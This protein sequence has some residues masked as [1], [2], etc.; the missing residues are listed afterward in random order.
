MFTQAVH[1]KLSVRGQLSNG[2]VSLL[3]GAGL[4]GWVALQLTSSKG[5]L[6][7][8]LGGAG[9][10]LFLLVRLALKLWS[11]HTQ[12]IS[13]S[14]GRIHL[15]SAIAGWRAR[16][17]VRSEVDML[18][19]Q[20]TSS[21]PR[22]L[23]GV[24][25]RF[26]TVPV[27]QL[28]SVQDLERLYH[29]IVALVVNTPASQARI[30]AAAASINEA[31][32][33]MRRRAIF[34]ECIVWSLGLGY[35]LEVLTGAVEPLS[36]A[37]GNPSRLIEIGANVAALSTKGEYDRWITATFLH[38]GLIHIYLNGVAL[39]VLGG[40]LE[41]VL[42]WHR[43]AIVY[44]SSA[45]IGSIASSYLTSALLSVGASGAVLL[46]GAR[47]VQ[48]T[49]GRQLPWDSANLDAGGSLF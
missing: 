5:D 22:L 36:F 19:M 10:A 29:S 39:W 17:V 30:Q 38:G 42:G 43:V 13:V 45:L 1:I 8:T 4:L 44:I 7:L 46:L 49:H 24:N 9:L 26:L 2:I 23:L 21:G 6:A 33:I 25:G 3:I 40:L 31:A 15:P 11:A 18:V 27:E 41:R 14:E 16:I 34:T 47:A 12:F 28:S 37:G 35:V 48:L 20:T 32:Y